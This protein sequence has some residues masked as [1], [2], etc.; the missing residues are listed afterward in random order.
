MKGGHTGLPLPPHRQRDDRLARGCRLSEEQA[1]EAL[2]MLAAVAGI[3][4]A[5]LGGSHIATGEA[6]FTLALVQLDGC[7]CGRGEESGC[8][9]PH[10]CDPCCMQFT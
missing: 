5:Q 9:P 6:K 8:G 7:V 4:E 3:R 1:V 2:E 10:P